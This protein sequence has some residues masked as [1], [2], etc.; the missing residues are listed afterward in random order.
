MDAGQPCLEICEDEMDDGQKPYSQTNTTPGGCM[1]QPDKHGIFSASGPANR[2]T[3]LSSRPCLPC[4]RRL[5]KQ[6]GSF[7]PRAL[8][9]LT[10]TT[11]PSVTLSPS[12]D[13]PVEPVIRSTL[14]RRFRAGTRRASPVARHVVVTVLSLPPRRSVGAASIRFRLPMLP[15]PSSWGLGLRG[16]SL[17]RPLL[18]SLLLTRRLPEGDVV[19]R[20]QSLGFPP[21]CYPNYGASDSYPGRPFSC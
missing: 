4:G 19:D 17:S 8:P 7:A 11:N 2:W 15:S 12:I 21:P 18:R 3:P 14:L 13:F 9:R 10:A 5:Y 1:R 20:L 16:Y 6:Q